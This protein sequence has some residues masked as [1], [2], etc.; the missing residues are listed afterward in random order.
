MRDLVLHIGFPKTGS[1]TLQNNI[2]SCNK[3]YLGISSVDNLGCADG[4]YDI[5]IDFAKGKNV[6]AKMQ[7]WR[8]EVEDIIS[9][10]CCKKT[11][12]LLSSEF[13]FDGN[14]NGIA[15][16]P[17][18][19]KGSKD[20]PIFVE[21]VDYINREVWTHGNVK[22]IITER[23]K[24]D[25]ICSKYAEASANIFM[26]N[27]NK[28]EDVVKYFCEKKDLSWINWEG[29]WFSPLRRVLGADNVLVLNVADLGSHDVLKEKLNG[30][31]P[32]VIEKAQLKK[33]TGMRNRKSLG[34]GEWTISRYSM[35]SR[36]RKMVSGN[37]YRK[38]KGG[39]VYAGFVF[40][41]VADKLFSNFF[42][43]KRGKSIKLNGELEN[44]LGLVLERVER[45]SYDS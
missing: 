28:F 35:A 3:N 2:L 42:Q 9:D 24:I 23:E 32:G 38:R 29:V 6:L 4:L 44:K 11:P 10:R 18:V 14:V 20:Q 8:K 19:P 15:E 31:A 43:F 17:L 39:G 7:R 1:T 26:C 21:F 40:F 25:W 41:K 22:V 5:F 37:M 30:F 45:E 13:F 33:N 27:Q 34:S 12:A 36:Y 16:F